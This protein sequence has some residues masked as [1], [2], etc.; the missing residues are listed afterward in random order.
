MNI[1]ICDDYQKM[2][3]KAAEI[4][5]QNV[6]GKKCVLGLATGSTPEGM[7]SELVKMCAAG[8]CDFSQV[9]TFNLDEYYPISPDDPQSYRYYMNTKLF[10]H[11]NIRPENT[12]VPDGSADDADEVCTVYERKIEGAG[13]IDIQVVGIGP[14]G[15]VGFNEPDNELVGPTHKTALTQSTIDANSRFFESADLVPTMALTMGMKTILSA[16]RILLVVNGSAKHA[17]LQK[18]LSGAITTRCPI[19]LLNLHNDVTLVCD[20]EA[21]YGKHE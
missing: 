12:N 20:K 5:S 14:N 11:I 13:G 16:R 10:N 17:P 1:I 8:M 4:V 7:Y 19:T 18:L 3:A 9:T 2:S 15:H 21:Y 6:D